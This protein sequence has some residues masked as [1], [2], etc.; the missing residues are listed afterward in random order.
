M[1]CNKLLFSH[2]NIALTGSQKVND[3]IFGGQLN[4]NVKRAILKT[5][6]FVN[7]N[8]LEAKSLEFIAWG[9]GNHGDKIQ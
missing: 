6:Q 7:S 8:K 3:Y 4:E 2:T 9:G 1:L 5:L